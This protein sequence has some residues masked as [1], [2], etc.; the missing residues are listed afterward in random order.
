MH[1]AVGAM[2]KVI[3]LSFPWEAY[4]GTATSGDVQVREWP[5]ADEGTG[6]HSESR[7]WEPISGKSPGS[8]LD[9]TKYTQA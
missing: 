1:L 4:A 9:F 2:A 8:S 7:S 5:L 6:E 3:T